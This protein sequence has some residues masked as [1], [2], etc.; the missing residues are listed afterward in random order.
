MY[1]LLGWFGVLFLVGAGV[2]GGLATV[3]INRNLRKD[4]RMAQF[5]SNRDH[6]NADGE[7]L[8][9]ES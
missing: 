1:Q 3:F 7:G 6:F 4:E 9:P 8:H 5:R 2:I